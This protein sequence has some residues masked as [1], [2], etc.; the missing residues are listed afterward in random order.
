[1]SVLLRS[2]TDLFNTVKQNLIRGA[3]FQFN[4]S[5]FSI[6]C[7]TSICM[8]SGMLSFPEWIMFHLNEKLEACNIKSVHT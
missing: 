2:H 4:E 3:L 8:S 6:H 7:A 1:M 5:L